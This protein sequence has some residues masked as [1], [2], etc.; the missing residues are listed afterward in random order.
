[1]A[2]VKMRHPERD[3][4]VTVSERAYDV[5]WKKKGWEL[6]N[7]YSEGQEF[8]EDEEVDSGVDSG[9]D[10]E[11]DDETDTDPVSSRI[12]TLETIEEEELRELAAELGIEGHDVLTANELRSLIGNTPEFYDIPDQEE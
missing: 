11:I 7:P 9:V 12:P 6:V 1:M 10:Y 4:V 3:D 2:E 5:I 8:V